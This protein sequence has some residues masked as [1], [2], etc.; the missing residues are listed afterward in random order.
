MF[1]TIITR[2][3]WLFYIK[4]KIRI[5]KIKLYSSKSNDGVGDKYS[6]HDDDFE[7]IFESFH[8]KLKAGK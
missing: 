7:D 1:S 3:Y 6:D 8:G 4:P 2:S 5:E